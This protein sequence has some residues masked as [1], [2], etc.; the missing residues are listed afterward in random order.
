MTFDRYHAYLTQ[1][2]SPA[3]LQ[4][5]LGVMQVMD[6]LAPLY[7]LDPAAAHIAGLVHDAG[8]ELPMEQMLEIAQNEFSLMIR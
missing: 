6:T 5:S 2:L 7:G 4:H 3:R 1:R 8:K